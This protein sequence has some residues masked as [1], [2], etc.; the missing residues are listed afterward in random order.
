MFVKACFKVE[1]ASIKVVIEM[2]L[3]GVS[4]QP[5]TNLSPH[6]ARV[7]F[8]LPGE[9]KAMVFD[10]KFEEGVISGEVEQAGARGVFQLAR[11]VKADARI[12]DEYVG[13]YQLEP[14]R[15]ILIARTE[16]GLAYQDAELGN[17]GLLRPLSET[18]FFAGRSLLTD[19]PVDVKITF[20][21]NENSA[22]TGLIYHPR[23][24]PA[25][26]AARV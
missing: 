13:A 18:S 4:A 17:V 16:A 24:L 9:G 20:V 2:P 22:V 3:E 15:V 1:G 5:L 23:G 7:H 25:K 26:T 14:D 8:E 12:F 21:K 6:A 10:G 19:F 11:E